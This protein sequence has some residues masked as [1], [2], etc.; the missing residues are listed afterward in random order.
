MK[1]IFLIMIGLSLWAHADFSRD[2]N[3]QIVSDNSTQLQWQDD[4]N[5]IKTW[6]EAIDYCEGVSIGGYDDWRLP[7]IN[8]LYSIADRRKSNPAINSTFKIVGGNAY[9]SSSTIV[10]DESNNAWCV[11]FQYGYDG[12]ASKYSSYYIRCVRS[13]Q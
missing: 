4:V 10:G 3:T 6:I 13:E 2:N 9:W 1:K 5:V 8:E 7:N 12:W 11:Y